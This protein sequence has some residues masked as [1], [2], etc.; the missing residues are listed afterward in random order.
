MP[1]KIRD[2]IVSTWLRE[3]LS[4]TEAIER[5][6]RILRSREI[7]RAQELRYREIIQSELD[8]REP[9]GRRVVTPPAT[10]FVRLL[11]IVLTPKFYAR[12]VKPQVVDMYDQYYPVLATG[13][14][15]LARWVVIR[16]VLLLVWSICKAP[17]ITMMDLF[18]R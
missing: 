5:M 9:V 12:V 10:V 17:L 14:A 4:R 1:K 16:S 8:C 6:V 18:R 7:Q 2:D 13:E 15:T 11:S 3:G